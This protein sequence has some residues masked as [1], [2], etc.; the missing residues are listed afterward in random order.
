M[1]AFAERLCQQALEDAMTSGVLSPIRSDGLHGVR[2][3]K[4]E[5]ERRLPGIRSAA[6][7]V[8]L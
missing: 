6:D 4:W 8:H 2:D 3:V 7:A 1:L 5:S